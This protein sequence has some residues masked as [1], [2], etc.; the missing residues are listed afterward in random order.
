MTTRNKRYVAIILFICLALITSVS[1]VNFTE[2]PASTR[3]AHQKVHKNIF[4]Q[5]HHNRHFARSL[6]LNK[7]PL[8]KAFALLLLVL[9]IAAFI[10]LARPRV[11]FRPLFSLRLKRILL[12]PIKFTS[13]FVA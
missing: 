9:P 1:L 13:M 5:D 6:F 4:K 12:S 10:L 11:S 3:T 2:D 7:L 8:E